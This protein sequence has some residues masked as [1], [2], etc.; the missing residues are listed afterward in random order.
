MVRLRG[1]IWVGPREGWWGSMEVGI[2]G[3]IQGGNRGVGIRERVFPTLPISRPWPIVL[4]INNDIKA[5][6]WF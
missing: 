5:F 1:S 6:S 3:G 2:E 4:N